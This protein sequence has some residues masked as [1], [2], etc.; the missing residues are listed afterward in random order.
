MKTTKICTK[1]NTEKEL[2][3]FTFRNDSKKYRNECKECNNLARKKHYEANADKYKKMAKENK[4]KNKE[5]YDNYRA[6][7][8]ERLLEYDRNNRERFKNRAKEYYKQ[9]PEKL[10]ARKE[11][12]KT[13]GKV[14]R[15]NPEIKEILAIKNKQWREKNKEKLL[16]YNRNP[17][18]KLSVRLRTH[19]RRAKIKEGNIKTEDLQL[20]IESSKT[21]YWCNSKLNKKEK[22]G[23]HLD[24]Y[25]ALSKGGTHTIDN[26]V[27]SC[28]DCNLRKNAK[29][30]YEFALTKGKLL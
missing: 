25:V 18:R 8:R 12:Q 5:Y 13:T 23:F 11:K 3:D 20:L 30:P 27:I 9:N 10:K 19:E 6:N 24:H 28:P 14:Y 21:C 17:E 16:E 7:N 22:A 29:D 15:S 1:C 26:I 2:T 4:I